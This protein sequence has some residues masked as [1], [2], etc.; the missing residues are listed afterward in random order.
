MNEPNKRTGD[1]G[2]IWIWAR[3]IGERSL[4][5]RILDYKANP[6]EPRGVS[7]PYSKEAHEAAQE[8][9]KK[10]RRG[11]Q[12]TAKISDRSSSGQFKRRGGDGDNRPEPKMQHLQTRENKYKNLK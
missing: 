9:Q 8:M 10:L 1:P 7:I 5:W 11:E 12:V 3:G 6:S 4:M 2:A